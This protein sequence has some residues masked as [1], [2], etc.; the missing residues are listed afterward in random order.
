MGP[1]ANG[2]ERS[3]QELLSGQAPLAVQ[4]PAA[5][6]QA[7]P[8]LGHGLLQCHAFPQ[9]SA[10]HCWSTP[11][12]T[13]SSDQAVGQVSPQLPS[14]LAMMKGSLPLGTAC[15]SNMHLMP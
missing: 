8:F 13:R 14:L 10:A 5:K 15:S 2:E 6:E 7:W 12:Q 4:D 3:Q 1:G 11:V 9:T